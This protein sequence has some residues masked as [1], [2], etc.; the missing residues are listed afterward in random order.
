MIFGT[1]QCSEWRI[2]LN[3]LNGTNGD[4]PVCLGNPAR[5]VGMD[6]ADNLKMSHIGLDGTI[7][8]A[9]VAYISGTW[10][11]LVQAL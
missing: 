11:S 1:R 2:I 3:R 8:E 10:H 6:E 5:A 7:K 9:S 4:N